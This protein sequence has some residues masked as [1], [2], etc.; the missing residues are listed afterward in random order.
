MQDRVYNPSLSMTYNIP[1][2]NIQ[3]NNQ[4]TKEQNSIQT[5]MEINNH[6][7]QPIEE[8]ESEVPVEEYTRPIENETT[9]SQREEVKNEPLPEDNTQ[10][11]E[12]INTPSDESNTGAVNT[13][14]SEEKQSD[15][16]ALENN[17][18]E[19]TLIKEIET[20]EVENEVLPEVDN[21]QTEEQTNTPTDQPNSDTVN[22]QESSEKE[23]NES[24]PEKVE[25]NEIE[26]ENNSEEQIN[27]SSDESNT[28]AV[29]TQE[30]EEKQ[31]D[32]TVPEKVE[33]TKKPEDDKKEEKK[34]EDKGFVCAIRETISAVYPGGDETAIVNASVFLCDDYVLIKKYSVFTKSDR[35][36]EKVLYNE[37]TTINLNLAS[38]TSLTNR[39][40]IRTN[41]SNSIILECV[42][43]K[44]T[45]AF[46]EELSDKVADYKLNRL[47]QSESK[48]VTDKNTS[49]SDNTLHDAN[50][51]KLKEYHEL[52]TQGVI[53]EEEF[54]EIKRKILDSI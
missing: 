11:G 14:E 3:P 27:T 25:E 7:N 34:K 47:K 26:P 30:S 4:P 10:T 51:S 36:S 41:G 29:N 52:L 40:E 15:E 46:Y 45:K 49:S 23:S 35:G 38:T 16:S 13:Q 6:T 24:T 19:E 12:Q 31:S 50:V 33:E 28:S 42:F 18:E 1:T 48:E 44:D 17:S 43:R 37:I 22:T 54:A 39:I 9:M 2:D 8:K 5:E 53:S 32:K 20:E 21:T